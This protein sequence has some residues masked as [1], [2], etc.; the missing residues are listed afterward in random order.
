MPSLRELIK[1]K[2][3]IKAKVAYETVWIDHFET[4]RDG[5]KVF[6]ECRPEP[7]Q[8]VIS[9]DQSDAQAFRTYIHEV[10]HAF[11][12]EYG[13]SIPHKIFAVLE[14]AVFRFLKLNGYIK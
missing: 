13:F 5:K 11:E 10:I 8:I 7:R 9:A 3:R 4:T 12:I 2:T 1:P 14:V 6:G